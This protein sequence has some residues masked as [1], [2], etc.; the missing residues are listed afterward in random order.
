M[1]NLTI[2]EI[3]GSLFRGLF[4]L[5]PAQTI[6]VNL[7]QVQ[8]LDPVSVRAAALGP[9]AALNVDVTVMAV[10]QI[11]INP[12]GA[13]GSL[14]QLGLDAL[15]L[16]PDQPCTVTFGSEPRANLNG[17][18]LAVPTFLEVAGRRIAVRRY[19]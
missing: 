17:I 5:L 9:N 11:P 4:G 8:T 19:P 16:V 6:A 1:A 7:T 10:Q 12:G 14:F 13:V 2:L 15:L 18:Y 3:R